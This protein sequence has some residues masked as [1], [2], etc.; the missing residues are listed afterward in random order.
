MK[1]IEEI[2]KDFPILDKKFTG[3]KLTY[4]DSA[5]TSQK[6]L[7][8]INR[9]QEFMSESNGT[10]RRGVYALSTQS[11]QAFDEVRERVRSFINAKNTKEIIFTRGTTEAINLVASSFCDAFIKA[12]D[13]I[14]ISAI[15]HHANI[16]P[17]QLQ[18]LRKGGKIQVIPVKDNGELDLEVYKSLLASGKVKIVA[19]NH[20]ANSLGTINPI[21]EMIGLAHE[22]GAYIL[23]DGAQGI[24]HDAVDVQALNCDF[25]CFSGHKLYGPTGVGVLYGKEEVLNK[26]PP[27]HGGGEMI[28]KVS[29]EKTTFAELPFKFEAGTPPIAEVIGLGEAIKYIQ[30]IGFD[31]IKKHETT[32]HQKLEEELKKIEGLRIIGTAENKASITSFV[33]DDIEAFDIGTMLNEHGVAIRTGHHC[34]QPVMDRYGVTSTARASLGLYNNEEDVKNFIEALKESISIF[35]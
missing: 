3:K 2:R 10:V 13:E 12:G 7:S 6:P 33:F 16:V 34:A 11:T 23:I 22:H 14:I 18:S 26:L 29:F 17:W 19:V 20:I 9:I 15:E 5:A 28:D 1:T 32:L 4:L 35:R 31:F 8:V 21:K 30:D 24:T 27:Y 25:Y